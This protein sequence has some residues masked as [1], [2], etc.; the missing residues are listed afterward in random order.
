MDMIHMSLVLFWFTLG[1]IQLQFMYSPCISQFIQLL[2]VGLF[3]L[4]QH[5]YG[6]A[7]DEFTRVD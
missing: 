3:G 4:L 7:L 1:S 6:L 5:Y 2:D